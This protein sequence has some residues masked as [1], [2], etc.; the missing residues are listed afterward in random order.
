MG[1][2]LE[3]CRARGVVL[4]EVFARRL[5]APA[6]AAYG[7][8]REG[9]G[10]S[11]GGHAGVGEVD[12]AHRQTEKRLRAAEDRRGTH[13]RPVRVRERAE[14]GQTLGGQAQR[15]VDQRE[16]TPELVVAPGAE[17]DVQLQKAL[18]LVRGEN[19]AALLGARQALVRGAEDDQV[20]HVPAAVAVE[21]A[22]ADAVEGDGDGPDVMVPTS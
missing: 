13:G 11:R 15:V 10:R 7:L 14:Q 17:V 22:R 20:L 18:P 8:G 5:L 12:D 3:R 6:R 19:A 9:E 4:R 16:L 1:R 21:V 2:L